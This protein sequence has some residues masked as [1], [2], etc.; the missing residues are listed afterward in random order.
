MAIPSG[1]RRLT[2]VTWIMTN[3]KSGLLVVYS[4]VE[5]KQRERVGFRMHELPGSELV[6]KHL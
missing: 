2:P 3:N 4:D 5:I 1:G 6:L